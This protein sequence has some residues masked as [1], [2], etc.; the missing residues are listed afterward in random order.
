MEKK[1]KTLSSDI[2]QRKKGASRI[3]VLITA[4]TFPRYLNDTEPRFVFDLAK[5]LL[6]YCDVTVLVPMDILAHEYEVM[7][8]V[9]VIRYHYFPIHKWETLCYPGAIVPRIKENKWRA[10]LVPFLFMSLWLHT[11]KYEKEVDLVN[12]H[13][14]IPQGIIQC[15]LPK[16]YIITGHGGD[17]TSL[18][19][20]II[21]ILKK[22]TL[23]KASA[24]TV[25]SSQLQK[26]LKNTYHINDI[27]I[28]P[29]GC[30]T[31]VF[32]PQNRVENYFKQNGNKVILFVGRLAEKKGVK[33]LIHAIKRKDIKLVIV[34]DGPLRK[35]LETEA[36]QCEGEITL[37]G[38]KNQEELPE[39]MASADIFVAPSITAEDG[40]TEGVPVSII[41]AMASGTPVISTYSGGI[42]DLITDGVNG[43]LVAEK[44]SDG[45]T[46]K[47]N[48]LLQN[49]ELTEKIRKNALE[50]VKSYDYAVIAKHYYDMYL[51]ALHED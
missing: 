51:Q 48:L 10:L 28:Q 31:H 35:A 33:Y 13:W 42:A 17:V 45:L 9:K 18:N 26:C 40:D 44:D 21:K 25:V 27:K 38:K 36:E 30:C 4:S 8:G 7:E 1:V 49:K 43:I 50:T 16:K 46:E 20:G 6:E 41:E 22:K 24:I 3:K 12:A 34:G 14:I 19:K 11:R 23:E 2:P 32:G 37:F 47:I 5:A 29:M 15:I 39:I